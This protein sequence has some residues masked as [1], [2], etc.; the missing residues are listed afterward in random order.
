MP[1]ISCWR[2][3]FGSNSS[4]RSSYSERNA[5]ADEDEDDDDDD[6]EEEDIGNGADTIGAEWDVEDMEEEDD[7]L[8]AL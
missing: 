7:A 1:K 8:A 5:G 2:P 4:L 3:A 6:D